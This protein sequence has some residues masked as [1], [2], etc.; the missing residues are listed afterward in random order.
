MKNEHKKCSEWKIFIIH[1]FVVHIKSN[2]QRSALDVLKNIL[3][4]VV[5][6]VNLKS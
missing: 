4:L 1:I 3:E 2:P 5:V 6:C